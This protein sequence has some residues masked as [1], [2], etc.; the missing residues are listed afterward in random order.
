MARLIAYECEDTDHGSCC[1]THTHIPRTTS[2]KEK[3]RADFTTWFLDHA[4]TALLPSVHL[5]TIMC[6]YKIQHPVNV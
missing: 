3:R 1:T 5:L 6:G 2:A 4:Y